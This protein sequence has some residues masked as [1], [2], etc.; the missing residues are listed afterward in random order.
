MSAAKTGSVPDRQLQLLDSLQTLL[1]QQIELARTGNASRLEQ[2]TKQA[3]S[4][5]RTIAEA[6]VLESDEL[7][8]RRER[9]RKLYRDLCLIVTAQRAE[10]GEKLSQIRKG[11]K[12]IKAYRSTI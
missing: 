12:T 11:R 9:L 4:L 6:G 1:E 8:D 5:V 10:T 3:D 7:R 2:L